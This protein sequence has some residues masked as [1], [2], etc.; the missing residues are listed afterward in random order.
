MLQDG[1]FK[2]V[3][4]SG[5]HDPIEF[6]IEALME[7]KK[8]DLG[9]GFF[10]SSGFKV[11]SHGFAY[12]ISQGGTMRLI[13]NNILTEKD[14]EAIEKG[15][16]LK[17]EIVEKRLIG[18]IKSLQK[19]LS[20]QDKHFFN[21]L[22]WLIAQEKLS[23]LAII[24]KN[25]TL[26]IAHHKFGIFSDKNS[27]K[28]AFTGSLNFSESAFY[29]NLETI[30]C[31]R[32][33]TNDKERTNYYSALFRN[34]WT[35]LNPSVEFVPIENIKTTISSLFPAPGIEELLK[36]ELKL[37]DH[38]LKG[39]LA[40][41]SQRKLDELKKRINVQYK[42]SAEK[43]E[44]DSTVPKPWDYQKV[45]IKEWVHNDYCGFFEMATGTG[46]T[47]TALFASLELKKK[48]NRC[49]ILVLVPTI[50]LAEQWREE[51]KKVGYHSIVT[52]SSTYPKWTSDLNKA[53]NAF[54]LGS[55]D[56]TVCI[57]TYDSYKSKRFKPFLDKFPDQSLL[58]ADEAHAMGA[59]QMLDDLPYFFKYRIGLSATPHRHFDDAGTE[60][61][62]EFFNAETKPTYK[63]DLSQAIAEQFLCQ[64]NLFPHTIELNQEE[65]ES[66]LELTKK[67]SKRAHIQKN[68]LE[69]SDSHLEKLLRDRRNIL[70]R[71]SGK[72]AV[73]D[74]II[75][76]LEEET[77][78]IKHTLVYCPEGNN[79]EESGKIIDDYGRFLG[80]TK[81]LR[82]GKFVG[83]TP[84]D[85]RR[86][87]LEDFDKGKIQCL[88]AMKC[89]DEGVDVKQT[90]TA[91][92]L[93]SSTNPR[94]YVQRRGRVLRT[95]S[96]KSFAYLHDI[97]AVPPTIPEEK[98]LFEVEKTMISQ[99]LRRYKEFAEDAINY[100]EAIEPIK[101]IIE[102]YQIEI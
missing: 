98:R 2:I 7:S 49:F 90:K 20:K 44:P 77:G 43:E 78:S 65:Y 68:R 72:L 57:C 94:Q 39:T 67:I 102:K 28:V 46:K 71:A 82:I 92:F 5:D 17:D 54:K 14:K 100:V 81:G 6:Y 1:D 52:V 73:L 59:P 42:E 50:S 4:S 96:S 58:I 10:S 3:Y 37:I 22:S 8:L 47:F 11:L 38:N 31:Y 95:H 56:H 21:C 36:A 97:L 75:D 88:L 69:R 45:A 63:L 23:I 55:T 13:I 84:P 24:P 16:E 85:E 62:L 87:L 18:D 30:S 101:P 27:D 41:S 40:K 12:F 15:V 66:Y 25:N 32:S 9:L 86:Q 70:N 61:L 89:L 74:K 19:T 91:I 99:E 64:Y 79:P 83:E 76:Q 35:G 29:Y 53:I 80:L 93:A 48:L 26:G 34:L 51:V 60:K 33:W